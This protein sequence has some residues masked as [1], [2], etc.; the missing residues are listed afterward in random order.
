MALSSHRVISSS[1]TNA[2]VVP[3]ATSRSTARADCP[4]AGTLEQLTTVTPDG[5]APQFI[6]LER[7]FER[8]DGGALAAVIAHTGDPDLPAVRWDNPFRAERR[9][10]G[11]QWHDDE[12]A[13]AGCLISLVDAVRSGGDPTYGAPQARLDQELAL[14]IRESSLN[15][16]APVR[17]P[18][19]PA[20]QRT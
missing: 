4:G 18:L 16:G 14:A 6:T 20:S 9:G 5:E 3:V 19:D 13:V 12:I 11:E 1:S 15:A 8:N 10:H 2:C 17:F 7:R